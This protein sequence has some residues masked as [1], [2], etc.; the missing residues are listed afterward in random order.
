VT[1]SSRSTIHLNSHRIHLSIVYWMTLILNNLHGVRHSCT[2]IWFWW[3]L[4]PTFSTASCCQYWQVG[5]LNFLNHKYRYVI[6]TGLFK[7]IFGVIHNTLQMQS[8]V[9][10]FYGVMSRIRFMFLPFPQVTEGTNQN[11]H[12][13][14]HRWHATTN[15][16]IVLMFVE[17]QRVH[18]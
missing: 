1:L 17:S 9:I 14:H 8:H 18:I 3:Q 7:M 2:F 11:R 6:Y 15:S 10:S 13:N 4:L 5:S 12:G 16:I